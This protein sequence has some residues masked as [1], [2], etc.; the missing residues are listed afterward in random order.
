MGPHFPAGRPAFTRAAA[1]RA[2]LLAQ[3]ADLDVKL[4]KVGEVAERLG[5]SRSLAYELAARGELPAV[6]ILEK[7]I[8]I[9][10]D[11]LEAWV[12]ARRL[13]RGRSSL[14]GR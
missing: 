9:P 11:A 4:L 13:D 3:G 2:C 10:A 14:G 7:A 1:A 8:R 5:I 12:E 6:R